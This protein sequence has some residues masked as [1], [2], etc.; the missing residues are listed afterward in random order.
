VTRKICDTFYCI[1]SSTFFCYFL[2]PHQH[3]VMGLL[4]IQARMRGKIKTAVAWLSVFHWP[5]TISILTGTS[6]PEEP[7]SNQGAIN[8]TSYNQ[9]VEHRTPDAADMHVSDTLVICQD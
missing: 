8:P 6:Q 3:P 9:E 4:V 5:I 2:Y 1:T 7:S